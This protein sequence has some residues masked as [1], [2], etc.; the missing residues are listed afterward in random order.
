MN[1]SVNIAGVEL[2]IGNGSVGHIWFR[3]GI[4]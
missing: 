2:R 3:H 4:Q 1:M